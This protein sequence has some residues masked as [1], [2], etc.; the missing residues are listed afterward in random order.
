MQLYCPLEDNEAHYT[1]I[2]SAVYCMTAQ[3]RLKRRGEEGG[4]TEWLH[5]EKWLLQISLFLKFSFH[6]SSTTPF[7]RCLKSFK[8][9]SISIKDSTIPGELC[10]YKFYKTLYV[11][12]DSLITS[13]WLQTLS[14]E[15][16]LWF[17]CSI[18][19]SVSYHVSNVRASWRL[20]LHEHR[21]ELADLLEKLL[22]D[23]AVTYLWEVTLCLLSVQATLLAHSNARRTR[24]K[25]NK[26][27]K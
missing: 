8:C 21:A 12:H 6:L 16:L 7:F 5:T 15:V 2:S 14:F 26:N 13:V 11:Q 23:V 20:C 17:I 25:I 9:Y 18:H 3:G 10:W 27:N 22:C 1:L 24:Q 19:P 4:W